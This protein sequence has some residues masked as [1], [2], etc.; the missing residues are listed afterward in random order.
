ME[1]RVF[2]AIFLCFIVVWVWQAYFVP[3]PPPPALTP[4]APGSPVTPGAPPT[5]SP[6]GA[7]VA[8]P[9]AVPETPGAAPLVADGAARDILIETDSVRRRR[10]A[11]RPG[12]ARAL[13]LRLVGPPRSGCR[14]AVTV[15][16]GR[17]SSLER[18]DV[19]GGPS[20][21]SGASSGRE[22]SML[23]INPIDT[24]TSSPFLPGA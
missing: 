2:L 22:R 7:A 5:E 16:K 19:K 11:V 12:G 18:P 13:Q 6:A 21:S 17:L 4:A 8:P 3:K 20:H 15:A 23:T 24:S 1:K 14:R 9:A 10:A